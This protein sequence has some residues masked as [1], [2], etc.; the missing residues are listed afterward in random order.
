MNSAIFEENLAALNRRHK[1][2]VRELPPDGD[3]FSGSPDPASGWEELV[4]GGGIGRCVIL[5]GL[6]SGDEVVHLWEQSKQTID[7]LII[8][9]R[10]TKRAK[11]ILRRVRLAY[12]LDDERVHLFI[13]LPAEELRRNL[14]PLRY[15]LGTS[16]PTILELAEG[17]HL[18]AFRQD[19]EEELLLVRQCAE[20][21]LQQKGRMLFN[22]LRNLP[23][24]V[25]GTPVGNLRGWCAGEPAFV[26]AAGP[27]LDKNISYLS[28]A[29]EH[30]WV[31]AVDTALAPLREAGVIP[32]L[33][34]TC[35]PTPLN[36]RHFSGW[37]DLGETILA[38][39]PEVHAEIPGTYSG[40]AR[41]LVLHD[42]E[43]RLLRCLDLAPRPGEA[44]AC[45]IMTAH[46]AFNLAVYLGCDPI[47]LVGLDLAFPSAGGSTHAA[48]AALGRP[49]RTAQ[50]TRA[51]VGA[52]S[53]LLGE[54]ETELVE[55]PGVHGGKVQGPPIFQ[56]YLRV[57]EQ[58]IARSGRRVIDAT[59]GGTKKARTEAMSLTKAIQTIQQTSKPAISR[60]AP[61]AGSPPPR[62]A[63]MLEVLSQGRQRLNALKEWASKP[64]KISDWRSRLLADPEDWLLPAY[65]SL[66]YKAHHFPP[67]TDTDQPQVH[68][69]ELSKQLISACEHFHLFIVGAE[70]ELTNLLNISRGATTRL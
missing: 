1:Q 65:E 7:L 31:I 44:L 33:L 54:T 27:S 24:I 51:T 70:Q 18:A 45:G 9:E 38:F 21:I 61:E 60:A 26:V 13:G 62:I 5:L 39:H 58:E 53:G 40:R 55:L 59:E 28:E 66:I 63:G 47:V 35:D 64:H 29:R 16:T 42:G 4:R 69:G 52:I 34:V 14:H 67:S 15:A 20:L 41:I 46:L 36:E 43:S 8:F 22:I 17:P 57:M 11:A 56:T 68:S 3:S 49:V 10:D 6:G 32:Q 23:A 25:S 12:I 30:G 48:G 37:P 19:L 50:G 2:A